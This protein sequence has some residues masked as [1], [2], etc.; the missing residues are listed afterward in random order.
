[1]VGN[2]KIWH[3]DQSWC[4]FGQIWHLDRSW[5]EFDRLGMQVGDDDCEIGKLLSDIKKKHILLVRN[6]VMEKI[7]ITE[8]VI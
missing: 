1:M 2:R 6:T 5:C 4:E 7:G 8:A 3:L